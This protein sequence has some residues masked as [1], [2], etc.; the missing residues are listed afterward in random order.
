[1]IELC[2]F[3]IFLSALQKK[4]DLF[5]LFIL[6]FYSKENQVYCIGFVASIMKAGAGSQDF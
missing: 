4:I 6:D 5:R 3:Q 1:M 2:D